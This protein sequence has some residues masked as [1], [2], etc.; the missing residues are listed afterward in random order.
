M[1]LS[2]SACDTS[3]I[4]WNTASETKLPLK[5]V[6]GGGVA[7]VRWSPHNNHERVLAATP[8]TVFRVWEASREWTHERWNVPKG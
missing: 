8:S 4:L 3:M 7:L 1:L 2:S 5:R 6:G